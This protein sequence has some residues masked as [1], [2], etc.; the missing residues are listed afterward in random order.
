MYDIDG[1]VWLE[2]R[3]RKIGSIR[4]LSDCEFEFFDVVYGTPGENAHHG[5]SNRLRAFY[6][7]WKLAEFL[8][9]EPLIYFSVFGEEKSF[10]MLRLGLRSLC[11]FAQYQGEI[12]IITDKVRAEMRQYIPK[13]L[14]KSIH[15]FTRKLESIADYKLSRY[16]LESWGGA[17][18]FGPI[19]YV[20]T[21]VLFD[22]PVEAIMID[23]A[24]ERRIIGQGKVGPLWRDMGVGADIFELDGYRFHKD[25]PEEQGFCT[26]TLGI[27]NMA[28]HAS[29]LRLIYEAA[30]RYIGS[31]NC[32]ELGWV[33]Q[34]TANY[35]LYKLYGEC[36][37]TISRYIRWGGKNAFHGG[38]RPL[39]LAHLWGGADKLDEMR[40]LLDM[41]MG[42]KEGASDWVVYLWDGCHSRLICRPNFI[43]SQSDCTRNSD[44]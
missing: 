27:P 11:A 16:G 4:V 17:S 35:M 10:E 12:L 34:P 32:E 15:I 8:K 18:R 33:D 39:G 6:D 44:R 37:D 22:S 5:L 40:D 14:M 30:I 41:M 25:A 28:E 1:S 24:L 36:P 9:Y 31:K 13:E 43:I 7:G 26:G 3:S 42:V 21:D 38:D 2:T 29:D 19:L 23:I 20:D